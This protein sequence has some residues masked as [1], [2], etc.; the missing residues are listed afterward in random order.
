[1]HRVGRR[2]LLALVLCL[3]VLAHKLCFHVDLEK[4]FKMTE[5]GSWRQLRQEIRED[6]RIPLPSH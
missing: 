5:D 2:E 6:M 1:M 3:Q 4:D